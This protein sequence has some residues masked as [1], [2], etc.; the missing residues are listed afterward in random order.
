MFDYY[1]ISW[2]Y[3]T[4]DV[5]VVVTYAKHP[6]SKQNGSPLFFPTCIL[7]ILPLASIAQIFSFLC[8]LSRCF[9][10][11]IRPHFFPIMIFAHCGGEPLAFIFPISWLK[12]AQCLP[13]SLCRLL[14]SRWWTVVQRAEKRGLKESSP[15]LMVFLSTSF[16][17]SLLG[18]HICTDSISIATSRLFYYWFFLIFWAISDFSGHF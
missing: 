12:L 4:S 1:K 13:S 14:W 3:I 9:I 8:F 2:W 5:D 18:S 15:T 16:C 7:M 11:K 10:M 6:I 17:L